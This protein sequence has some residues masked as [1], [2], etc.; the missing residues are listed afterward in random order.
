MVKSSS[1]TKWIAVVLV[2]VVR[3]EIINQ[4]RHPMLTILSLFGRSPFAP[5]QAHMENVTKC[6]HQ[7]RPLFAALE[8][9]DYSLVELI[10]N[11]IS[12][13]EHHADLIK[14]DIRN[15]LRNALFMP[16]SR[17]NIFKILSLQD[18]IA[19]TVE[20]VAVILLIKKIEFY[21]PMKKQFQLFLEKNIET[22]DEA[23]LIIKELHEL[24][25]FS[26]GGIEAEKVRSMVEKV[27]FKE[28]EVDLI[29]RELL[30]ELLAAEESM[31]YGTFFQWQKIFERV[32]SV[33]NL[34]ENL[35]YSIRTTLELK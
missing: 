20:D 5:L 16:I 4:R 15:H 32:A 26:F 13:L 27:A 9:K 28:H 33:S 34:S 35:A 23:H 3:C 19:D 11:E 21:E 10:A 29:Q 31:S 12:E 7:L 6:V 25:E 22:F 24:V 14:N 1:S 17:E 18:S 30:K 2:D 8:K